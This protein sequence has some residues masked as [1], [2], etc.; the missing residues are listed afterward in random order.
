MKIPNIDCAIIVS[1]CDG[2]CDAWEPFFTLFFRYWPDCPYPIYLISN[3]KKYQDKKVETVAVDPDQ[4]WSGNLLIALSRISARYIIYFQEDYFLRAK[5]D[6]KKIAE[7]LALAEETDAAYLRLF[8]CPG[9]DMSYQ[10]HPD[11]GLISQNAEYR[12]STQTAIWNRQ[13]LS[14]LLRKGESGWDFETGGGRERS[15]L[16]NK[17]FF[18]YRQPVIDYF[19]TAIVKGKYVYN[20]SAFARQEGIKL[21]RR[22]RKMENFFQYLIRLSGIK[23]KLYDFIHHD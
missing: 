8:P 18:T 17:P 3:K 10:N 5:V 9:P 14:S 4:G 20:L 15:R 19:C 23:N 21:D 2:Y 16:V 11:I 13:T 12:N 1:S 6:N 7:A 22:A